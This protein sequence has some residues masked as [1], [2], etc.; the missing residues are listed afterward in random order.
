MKKNKRNKQLNATE[1]RV[2]ELHSILDKNYFHICTSINSKYVDGVSW[3]V[4]YKNL[5]KQQ[6]YSRKN[7]ELLSSD[8]NTIEDIYKLKNKFEKEKAK[9]IKENAY[10]YSHISHSVFNTM[11]VNKKEFIKNFEILMFLILIA[12]VVNLFTFKCLEFSILST[13]YIGIIAIL[14]SYILEQ[15]DKLREKVIHE[16][17]D[18]YVRERIRRQGLYF[19]KR[20]ND[21]I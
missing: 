12:S 17:Q 4:Y 16:I 18:N 15:I 19:V 6:Y 3:K 5:P 8:K 1:K 9:I 13:L 11:Y 21:D 14:G 20:L 7:R 2:K 10:E